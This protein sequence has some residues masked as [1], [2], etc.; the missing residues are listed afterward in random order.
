[1][2]TMELSIEHM[3]KSE[4]KSAQCSENKHVTLC[5]VSG[6][7]TFVAQTALVKISAG[8]P[9]RRGR[10]GGACPISGMCEMPDADHDPII[11]WASIVRV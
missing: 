11:T 9:E 4:G 3:Q 8:W 1:M 10:L 6:V 7:R 2:K 5:G